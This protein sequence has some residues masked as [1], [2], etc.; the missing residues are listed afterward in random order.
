M[1][2]DVGVA[3]SHLG[4]RGWLGADRRVRE[5]RE[6]GLGVGQPLVATALGVRVVSVLEQTAALEPFDRLRVSGRL[7]RAC[8]GA[9]RSR[10]NA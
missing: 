4:S 2:R 7:P 9:V 10:G 6:R 3:A 1:Q 8:R 5:S